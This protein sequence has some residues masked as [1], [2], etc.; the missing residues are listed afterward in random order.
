[1]SHR[2][3]FYLILVIVGMLSINL[4][5]AEES[6]QNV[7][8][9]NAWVRALPPSQKTTAGL[10]TIENKTEKEIILQS[11]TST[12]AEVV[13]IH[14][15]KHADGMMKMEKADNVAIPAGGLIDFESSGYHLMLINLI[16]PLKEGDVVPLILNFQDGSQIEVSAVVKQNNEKQD[17]MEHMHHHH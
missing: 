2:N 5:R 11:V 3:S 16:N 1:M 14:K 6:T 15:M 10:L 8:I 12:A 9:S 13:E 4:A 17:E 7:S